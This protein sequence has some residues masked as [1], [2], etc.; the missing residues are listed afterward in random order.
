MAME[1]A[2]VGAVGMCMFGENALHY[3]YCVL[4]TKLHVVAGYAA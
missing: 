3:I 2:G 4:F 1:G